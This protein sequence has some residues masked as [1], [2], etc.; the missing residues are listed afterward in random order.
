MLIA[1]AAVS[2]LAL[3]AF[4]VFKILQPV[5]PAPV[6]RAIIKVEPGHWLDG[7]RRAAEAQRPSQTAMAI[8]GD[9]RFVAYS[10]IEENP[11]PQ[12]KPRLYLRKMDQV[13]AR[14]ITGTEGGTNP[15]LSPDNRRVGFWADGKLKTVPVD[16]GVPAT[17]CDVPFIFGANILVLAGNGLRPLFQAAEIAG[18]RRNNLPGKG[19]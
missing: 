19:I 2:L 5:A 7:M 12:A 15:F 8:S 17:L 10:A 1:G 14:P 6:T 16:G 13:E 3:L 18:D 11:G 4:A 9:G